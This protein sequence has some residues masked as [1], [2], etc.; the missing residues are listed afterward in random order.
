MTQ[1][2]PLPHHPESQLIYPYGET[3]AEAGQTMEIAPGIYWIRMP[4]PFAL[5]HINLWLLKDRVA[6]QEGWTIIDCG[7]TN[8]E[9]KILWE[10]IFANHLQGLPILRVLVTHMHPDHI[11]LAHFLCERWQAPLW[12]SMSDFLMA[13][14]LSSKEGG[15]AIGASSGSG[16]AADH[17]AR[18]GLL[19]SEDLERIRSR[20]DYY[21]RLVPQV[22]RR[23]RRIMEGDEVQIGDHRWKVS[24][25]YGHAPEHATLYCSTLNIFISGD[26]VLPRISTNVSVYDV[27]P[28]ADPLG[29]YLRSLDQWLSLPLD[30]FVLP[31]HGKPF[32]GLHTRIKQLHEHHRDRLSET[33]DAC[34]SPKHAFEI[35]PVL[36]RR[37]LDNHQLSFAMGEAIAHL[38]H[39]WHRRKLQRL[40]CEDGIWRFCVVSP[41]QNVL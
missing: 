9:T 26:M 8:D 28:D 21:S 33:L 13:Q 4:L 11:G 14:W 15:V 32:K 18:H 41:S 6:D 10:S 39:L 29:L 34:Q 20:S 27:D 2:D 24:M 35:I 12:V 17:Y 40:L 23:Y 7:I 31:S 1:V 19:G 3:L 16:G 36:F 37:K 5:N 25:G 22:P 30:A 38:N